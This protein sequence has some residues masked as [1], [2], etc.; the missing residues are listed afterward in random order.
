MGLGQGGGAGGTRPARKSRQEVVDIFRL[1]LDTQEEGVR[2]RLSGKL[3]AESS[4]EVRRILGDPRSV[5]S[6][7]VSE[8]GAVDDV[9][10][11]LLADLHRAG[12]ELL[13]LSPYL[14]LRL[15][16]LPELAGQRPGG[17]SSPTNEELQANEVH[18]RRGEVG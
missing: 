13:G 9:G 14:R 5:H 16:L 6:A 2:C 18:R 3:D 10:L 7:E 12:V 1:Q 4:I 17:R 15:D 8:L 11:A